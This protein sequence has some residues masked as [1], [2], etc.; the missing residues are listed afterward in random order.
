MGTLE[1]CHLIDVLFEGTVTDRQLC[2]T[3]AAQVVRRNTAKPSQIPS[4]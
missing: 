4:V 2:L 3:N 1:E